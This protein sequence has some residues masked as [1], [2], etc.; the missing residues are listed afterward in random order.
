MPRLCAVLLLLVAADATYSLRAANDTVPAVWVMYFGGDGQDGGQKIATDA[1]GNTYVL[2]SIQSGASGPAPG[3]PAPYLLKFN[4]AGALQYTVPIIG[5]AYDVAAAPDGT[6][7]VVGTRMFQ[8]YVMKVTS[9]GSVAYTTDLPGLTVVPSQAE[10]PSIAAAPSGD[11]VVAGRWESGIGSFGTIGPTGGEDA[12]VMMLDASGAVT[13]TWAIGG[14]KADAAAD[15]AVDSA[16]SIYVVGR[17]RSEDFP[18]TPNAVRPPSAALVC[19]VTP[20]ADS[21]DNAFVVKLDGRG[22]LVFATYYGGSRAERAIAV[23]VDRT[24]GVYIAGTTASRNF[25]VVRAVQPASTVCPSVDQ[26]VS[27]CTDNLRHALRGHRLLGGIRDIPRRV[28]H[29]PRNLRGFVGQ[30]VRGRARTAEM[31][32]PCVGRRN[33]TIPRVRWSSAKTADGHGSVRRDCGRVRSIQLRGAP[34]RD[35]SR[36]RQAI[37]VSSRARISD[38]AGASAGTSPPETSSRSRSIR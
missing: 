36:T 3:L 9:S 22:G 35:P 32:C 15:V 5:G 29:R 13:S 34:E 17:T 24:R 1:G 19:D 4:V 33:R 11:V 23:G 26:G 21:C 16:G 12:V 10:R 6:A 18:M 20:F 7:F 2:A 37:A 38:A 31:I 14:S 25:P 8:I 28:D 30:R 27:S